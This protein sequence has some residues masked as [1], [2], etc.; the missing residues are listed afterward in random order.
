MFAQIG[1]LMQAGGAHNNGV[2]LFNPG[3]GAIIQPE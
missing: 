1:N 3:M 2:G